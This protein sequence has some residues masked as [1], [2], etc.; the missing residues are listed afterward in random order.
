MTA[1]NGAAWKKRLVK[2]QDDVWTSLK[3]QAAIEQRPL[4]AV[5]ATACRDYIKAQ[6]TQRR[7]A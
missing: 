5:L 4:F 2:V 1:K 6:R 3:A 7:S